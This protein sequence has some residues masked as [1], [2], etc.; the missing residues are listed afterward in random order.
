MSTPVC[1]NIGKT[2][3]AEEHTIKGEGTGETEGGLPL[4]F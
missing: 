3:G 1:M 4:F 2:K